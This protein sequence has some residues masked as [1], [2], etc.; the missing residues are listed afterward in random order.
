VYVGGV[1]LSTPK[2]SQA[3]KKKRKEEK[4]YW[5]LLS[6]SPIPISG[7]GGGG[8][9]YFIRYFFHYM[10]NLFSFPHVHDSICLPFFS[11]TF[12]TYTPKYV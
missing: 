5:T 12:N 3:I 8:M 7:R 1:G 10:G 11:F 6:R 4:N 2:S 9:S